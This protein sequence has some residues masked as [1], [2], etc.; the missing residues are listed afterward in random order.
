MASKSHAINE[1]VTVDRGFLTGAFLYCVL[2]L[3]YIP[4]K[5][6]KLFLFFLYTALC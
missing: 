5:F 3:I 2:I 1:C 4:S 6:E